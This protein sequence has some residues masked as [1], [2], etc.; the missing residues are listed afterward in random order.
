MT[1]NIRPVQMRPIAWPWENRIIGGMP[2]L[3]VSPGEIEMP[4]IMGCFDWSRCEIT[5][6]PGLLPETGAPVFVASDLKSVFTTA[7]RFLGFQIGMLQIA[8]GTIDIVPIRAAFLQ[9]HA[10]LMDAFGTKIDAVVIGD[11]WAHNGGMMISPADW[12]RL[13]APFITAIVSGWGTPV[14]VHSDGDIGRVIDDL[15]GMHIE[16]LIYERVGSLRYVGGEYRGMRMIPTDPATDYY[17]GYPVKEQAG[18]T[19]GANS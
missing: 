15:A 16:G 12:K 19:V 8:D 9:W 6:R 10:R 2:H 7:L 14:Y 5:E 11:D 18:S 17:P 1:Y 4:D 3:A 13:V